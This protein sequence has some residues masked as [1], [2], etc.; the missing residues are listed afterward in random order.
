MGPAWHW[1]CRWAKD[2]D[3]CRVWTSTQALEA[4]AKQ[5]ADPRFVGRSV[6]GCAATVVECCVEKAQA[7][8]AGRADLTTAHGNDL[9]DTRQLLAVGGRNAGSPSAVN[10]YHLGGSG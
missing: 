7:G 10:H 3:C 5:T 4:R 2:G 8:A 9:A 6:Y 1:P